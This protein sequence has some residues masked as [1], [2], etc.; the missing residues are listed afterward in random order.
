MSFYEYKTGREILARLEHEYEFMSSIA[1]IAKS[2]GITTGTFTAIG[3]LQHAKVGY[4][5]QH[6]QM[7]EDILIP[8]HCEIA[9]C[10]GNISLKD[11]EIFVHAHA[12]LSDDKG[13]SISGHMI[14][15]VV[16][17]AE[18]NIRELI[19]PALERK[20]DDVTGLSLWDIK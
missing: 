17:A 12:V 2:E 10:I 14:S 11:E 18:V 3:A 9:S 20:H 15:G 8:H 13:N 6:K 4:Y 5:D 1:R 7:Y 16:F 19:G